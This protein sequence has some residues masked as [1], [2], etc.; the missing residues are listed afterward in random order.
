M[1][2]PKNLEVQT[3]TFTHKSGQVSCSGTG[4]LSNF[5]CGDDNL[6][7]VITKHADKKVI[8]PTEDIPGV[9]IRDDWDHAVWYQ[10][11][12][13]TRNSQSMTWKLGGQEIDAGTYDVWYVPT[14]KTP[15]I[16]T[17][18]Q[19]WIC[20]GSESCADRVQRRAPNSLN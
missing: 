14:P 9:K 15:L 12:G 17:A 6:A 4:G 20:H 11:P 16:Q 1:T 19:P 18:L 2:L 3:I 5:G 13:V 8:L 7:L 10:M